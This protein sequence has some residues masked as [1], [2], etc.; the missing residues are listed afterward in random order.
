[1]SMTEPEKIVNAPG[2]EI[3]IVPQ[4][5]VS[6]FASTT[7]ISSRI[8]GVLSIYAQTRDISKT[9]AAN[10]LIEVGLRAEL[11]PKL[12]LPPPIPPREHRKTF[13]EKVLESR[14]RPPRKPPQ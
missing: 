8:S 14:R 12:P 6:P 3:V 10:H 11:C 9:K 1:M 5:I 7:Q 13:K 2:G 4:K